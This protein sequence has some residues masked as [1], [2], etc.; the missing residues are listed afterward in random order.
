MSG[1]YPPS[2]FK[3]ELACWRYYAPLV[4]HFQLRFELSL[5]LASYLL[6]HR[7]ITETQLREILH[8]YDAEVGR[9]ERGK[10]IGYDEWKRRIAW[11]NETRKR[12]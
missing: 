4:H 8:A 6:R 7:L 2:V 12:V 3:R 1:S 10:R 5:F 9:I 11:L